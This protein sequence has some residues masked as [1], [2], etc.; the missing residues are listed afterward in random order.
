V[1]VSQIHEPTWFVASCSHAFGDAVAGSSAKTRV[2]RK[3]SRPANA[4]AATAAAKRIWRSR[5]TFRSC[6]AEILT[7]KPVDGKG[8]K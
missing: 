1:F 6:M 2:L 4:L 8:V 5:W 3:K 7:P